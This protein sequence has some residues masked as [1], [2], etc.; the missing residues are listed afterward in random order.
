[1]TVPKKLGKWSLFVAV[2]FS[3]EYGGDFGG[4][5]ESNPHGNDGKGNT[6][7][8]QLGYIR[9]PGLPPYLSQHNESGEGM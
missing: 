2:G 4:I 6:G 7:M 8:V 3:L 9:V 5:Q 1:M